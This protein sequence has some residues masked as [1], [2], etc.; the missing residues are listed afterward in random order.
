MGMTQWF[1][2]V[3]PEELDRAIADPEWAKEYLLDEGLP[4]CYLEKAWAGIQFLLD[5]AEVNVDLY[6][7][8]HLIDK[9]CIHLGW[10]EGM[11]A[12]AARELSATPFAALA[13][14]YDPEKMGA[15]EVYPYR[16]FWDENGLDW[17]RDHHEELVRFFEATA[18]SGGAA[19]RSF[20]F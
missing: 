10:D 16:G 7:D 12:D 15:E 20:S 1:T 3:S 19:I 17:L 14:H 13:G 8:G 2:R 11:I 5:A 4:S 6:E 9:E 18:A